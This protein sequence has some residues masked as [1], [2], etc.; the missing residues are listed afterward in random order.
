VYILFCATCIGN[1]VQSIRIKQYI[2]ETHPQFWARFD[3]TGN[4][5]WVPALREADQLRS[6]RHFWSQLASCENDLNDASLK[7]MLRIR[8]VLQILGALL[9]VAVAISLFSTWR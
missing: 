4:G 5:W 6:D 7:L 9:L 2:R 3:F 1:V 8:R